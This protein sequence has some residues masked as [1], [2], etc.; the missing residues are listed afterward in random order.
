M[1]KQLTLTQEDF[2]ALLG[3]LSADRNEAGILY[4]KIREGLMRFFRFRGCADPPLLADETINRVA[5]KIADFD[6]SKNVKVITYFY[7]FA[8][9]VFYEYS[10]A[11]KSQPIS[12]PSEDFS[13][14][15]S[16]LA[17]NDDLPN[18]ECDCLEECLAKLP[19]E[20]GTLIVQYYG[21]DKSEKSERRKRMAEHLDLK[22]P[23]LHI[24]VFRIRNSLREC[25]EKCVEKK[26]L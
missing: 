11:R 25:V 23:A 20:D 5:L 1:E 7:G 17:A 22:M 15:Q 13:G 12:L 14:E 6:S 4:E 26:S 16:L 8:T 24:K 2:D 9:N 19:R 18:A 3:W 10:R 21:T